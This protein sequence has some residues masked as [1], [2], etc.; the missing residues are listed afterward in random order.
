[1]NALKAAVATELRPNQKQRRRNKA[2][3]LRVKGIPIAS[4]GARR[5]AGLASKLH[6]GLA[7]NAKNVLLAYQARL[8]KGSRSGLEAWGF[9]KDLGMVVVVFK[10]KSRM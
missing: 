10:S 2:I 7:E 6:E 3:V 5:V 1:M 4:A 8:G 9:D